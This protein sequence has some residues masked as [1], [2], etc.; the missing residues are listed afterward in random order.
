[1][2]TI[3]AVDAN[4]TIHAVDTNDT[5]HAI[6]TIH[7]WRARTAAGVR[8]NRNVKFGRV[9]I[10]WPA[11]FWRKSSCGAAASCRL[12]YVV[13]AVPLRNVA[14]WLDGVGFKSRRCRR[15]KM[16]GKLLNAK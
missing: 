5:N 4:D 15:F 12:F 13:Y 10:L 1:M 14:T 8:S 7:T 16:G 2:Q 6:H 9:P 3:H 11:G